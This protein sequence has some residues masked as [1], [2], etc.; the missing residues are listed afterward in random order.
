[1]LPPVTTEEELE[2]LRRRLDDLMLGRIRYEGM[3]FQLDTAT[4]RYEDV[5]ASSTTFAGPSLNYRKVKD[6]EYDERFLAFLQHD[7]FQQLSERY[8]GPHVACMRAMVMNKPAHSGTVLPYHQDVSEQWN[9][10]IP[11][12]LTI[13]TA[14]DEA[15]QANGCVEIVPRSHRHGRIGSGHMLAPGEEA[16]Y[17]PSGSSRFVELKPGESMAFH[18]A[19][20]HRSGV[21][22]TDRPRRGFTVCLMDAATRHTKTGKG[23]PIL[24]GPGA[25]TPESVRRL[26]RIPA[27]VYDERTTMTPRRSDA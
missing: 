26:T 5:D 14:L 4:G 6:L 22:R 8:I 15:T 11:P 2:G 27:H 7:V 23:Y 17:A 13:W 12:V 21:N 10:T 3:F 18:N 9:M 20:L 1:M 25:L 19:L 24:F 16:R